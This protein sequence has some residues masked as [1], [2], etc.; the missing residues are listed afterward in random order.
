M[1]MRLLPP[2]LRFAGVIRLTR[3]LVR[4]R[5]PQPRRSPRPQSGSPTLRAYHLAAAD[6]NAAAVLARVRACAQPHAAL[7]SPRDQWKAEEEGKRRRKKDAMPDDDV[8]VD[9]NRSWPTPQS[10]STQGAISPTPPPICKQAVRQAGPS[11]HVR[12]QRLPFPSLPFLFRQEIVLLAGSIRAEIQVALRGEPS[13]ICSKA[14]VV[15][16]QIPA[17]SAARA[18]CRALAAGRRRR[19]RRRRGGR[20][21]RRRFFFFL[22]GMWDLQS[23]FSGDSNSIL[24]RSSSARSP[25]LFSSA[26]E[27]RD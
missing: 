3:S 4:P 8:D 24:Q 22:G 5:P 6:V 26:A 2:F 9:D 11:S 25:F 1:E 10:L 23:N 21:R 12:R 13:Q 19:R 7:F 14:L 17:G 15:R 16:G 20:K 27:R 18:G